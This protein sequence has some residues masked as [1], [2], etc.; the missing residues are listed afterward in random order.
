MFDRNYFKKILVPIITPFNSD[1]SVDYDALLSVADKLIN[2]MKADSLILT[3]TTGEFF[4]MNYEERA[5]VYSLMMDTFGKR[6]P[7]IAGTGAASTGEAVA[8]S[9]KAE[10]L[11]YELVMVLAPYYTKP[12]QQEIFQHFKRVSDEIGINMIIYNMPIFAG[13]NIE[14]ETVVPLSRIKN[15]VGIK[16]EAELNP[17]QITVFINVTEEDFVIYCG[18]DTMILEAYAQGGE[19]RIGGVVSGGSHLI[20]DRIRSMI[21]SFIAGNL[22][23]AAH[24]QQS[25]FPLFRALSPGDRTN[26]VSLLKDAMNMIG[27]NA[28]IPRLPLTPG[29]DKEKA[30]LRGVMRELGILE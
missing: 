24:M 29:T 6:I 28:G 11:G 17:K 20:G 7:L 3:G 13:V 8:L 16:E 22:E 21:E 12:S 10:E 26:P 15:I 14:P 5:K 9:R 25:F 1:Q 19:G 4:T 2:D 23:Q 30:D 27:Y 18:D